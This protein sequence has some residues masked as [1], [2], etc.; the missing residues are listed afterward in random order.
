MDS[1][2]TTIVYVC[3]GLVF[4]RQLFMVDIPYDKTGRIAFVMQYTDAPVRG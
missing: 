1:N 3:M 4:S 2:V